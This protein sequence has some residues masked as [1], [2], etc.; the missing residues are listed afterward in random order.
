MKFK[1]DPNRFSLL[2]WSLLKCH[3]YVVFCILSVF[4]TVCY[5]SSC[6]LKFKSLKSELAE[7]NL[8]VTIISRRENF[9]VATILFL[10][11]MANQFF[12]V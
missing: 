11:H 2:D 6:M 8:S 1:L 4:A 12:F 10:H 5:E 7:S 9:Q 3:V